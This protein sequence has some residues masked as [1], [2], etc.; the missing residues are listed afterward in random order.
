MKQHSLI[1][2]LLA[3]GFAISQQ[4]APGSIISPGDRPGSSETGTT[5]L[6]E[7]IIW[8]ET[9]ANGIPVGWTNSGNPALAV[10]E[11]R[12]PLTNPD[13]NSGSRGS[14]L[15]P[16]VDFGAPIDSETREDGFVIFDSNYW[17]DDEGP[18][19]SFGSGQAAAPQTASLTTPSI[20]L[21]SYPFV[22]I[23]FHQY[24]KNYTAQMKVQLSISGGAYQT[25]YTSA[26]VTNAETDRDATV[27]LN[28]GSIAGN[29]GDVKIRFLFEGTYYFWMIDDLQVLELDANDLALSGATY[30]DFDP[31]NPDHPTGY[32]FMEYSIYPQAMLPLLKFSGLVENLGG[33]SQSNTNLSVE[34]TKEGEPGILYANTSEAI[35]LEAGNAEWLRSGQFTPPS[36]EG[37]Y[38]VNFD[39]ASDA[40]D[41]QPESNMSERRLEIHPY[42][43]ARDLRSLEAVYVPADAQQNTAY[44]FG[45]IFLITGSGQNLASIACALSLGT[46]TESVVFGKLYEFEF[47]AGVVTANLVAS[48]Q[49][50]MVSGEDLNSPGEETM[51]ILPFSNEVALTEGRAYAAMVHAQAGAPSVLSGMSGDSPPF[52]S[53]V[54]FP[55]SNSWFILSKIPMVRM[56]LDNG[57]SLD[58]PAQPLVQVYPNPASEQIFIATP[59]QG[60][61]ALVDLSGKIVA[62]GEKRSGS[63]EVIHVQG[64]AEGLYTLVFRTLDGRQFAE[65]ILL[66]SSR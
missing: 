28:V 63:P 60:L 37:V 50:V 25:V 49:E 1:A 23:S 30:G 2:L 16:G 8:Q 12:G 55:G 54:H 7:T 56:Y 24:A 36:E 40:E 9:F 51:L 18:C 48:T 43:Y 17:D 22:G 44:E 26:L 33:L 27:R 58:E 29:E 31:N 41:D 64:M 39:A 66:R 15:P 13:N 53:W 3:P 38:L 11:Y 47:Q 19:G 32:E 59:L 4:V 42:V 46:L 5:E 61:Y 57:N 52:T 35:N 14:C 65:K 62:S 10:W 21:S 34:V 6:R 20:D 45:N